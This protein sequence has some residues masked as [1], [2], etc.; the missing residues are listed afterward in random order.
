MP[1]WDELA[2]IVNETW[3]RE[4]GAEMPLR[5]MAVDTGYNTSEAYKFCRRFD[6]TKVIPVKGSDT[7][8][9]I[10][11]QPRAIDVS[12]KGK[13]IGKIKVWTVGVSVLKSE[14]YGFLRLEKREDGSAPEGYCH[15]PQYEQAYFRGLTAEQLEFRMIRGFRKY[16]WVKKYERNEPL[17]LR[18]Y[19]R[20]AASVVG[21]DRL[22]DEQLKIIQESYGQAAAKASAPAKKRR[23]DSIW[24]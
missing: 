13:K 21:I 4:D 17:D 15:F 6:V 8:G 24:N 1:V 11:S 9:L 14:L 3:T 10:V 7:L 20:A 12:Q 18:N 19:A 5:M 23:S 2:K 16:Q 22:K